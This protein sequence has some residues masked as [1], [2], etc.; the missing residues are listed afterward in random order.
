[1]RAIGPPSP[2]FSF[3]VGSFRRPTTGKSLRLRHVVLE[4]NG[5]RL[6]LGVSSNNLAFNQIPLGRWSMRWL[7]GCSLDWFGGSIM[8]NFW[9]PQDN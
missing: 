3:V 6:L 2:F 5:D 4:H 1:V 7:T 9:T 8:D